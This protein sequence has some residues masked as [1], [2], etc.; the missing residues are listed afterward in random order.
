MFEK[1]AEEHWE[2]LQSV[3]H[4]LYVEAMIH[5]YKHG[6]QDAIDE[7]NEGKKWK[8]FGEE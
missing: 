1:E 5:G 3:I 7:I 4:K 6:Y 8:D 2:W